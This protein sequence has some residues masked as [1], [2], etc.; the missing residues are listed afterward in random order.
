MLGGFDTVVD[1]LLGTGFSGEVR[2]KYR[3]VIDEI[4]DS[5]AYVI[6]AD[7]NSGMNG[8]TGEYSLAVR[9]D[10]TVTI[11]YLK[12]GLVRAKLRSDPVIGSLVR[13]DI[14]IGLV[15]EEHYLLSDQE[16]SDN[17]LPPELTEFDPGDGH[18]RFRNNREETM[19]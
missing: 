10:L 6:S 3:D 19:E 17:G 18:I 13:T 12:T 2:G 11:G 5:S 8:D 7:I 14:G 1:C 16:W 9:S 15:R 4:N